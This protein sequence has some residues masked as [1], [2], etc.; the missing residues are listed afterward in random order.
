MFIIF[1]FG[2]FCWKCARKLFFF[3]S[4]SSLLFLYS[5]V[6]LL[7]IES[8]FCFAFPIRFD[9]CA[10]IECRSLLVWPS[11]AFEC[12]FKQQQQTIL[13]FR[14][15]AET[16]TLFQTDRRPIQRTIYTHIY[17][18]ICIY[19]FSYQSKYN[20]V[21]WFIWKRNIFVCW[22]ILCI[23][24]EPLVLRSLPTTKVYFFFFS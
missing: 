5:S 10:C 11:K 6:D 18:Y 7:H 14:R 15:S 3:F 4:F 8:R 19:A 1:F 2:S 12:W 20:V 16:G 23:D 17:I 9:W 24:E 22:T 13:R 21:I